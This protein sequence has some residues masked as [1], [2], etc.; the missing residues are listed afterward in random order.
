MSNP[1]YPSCWNCHYWLRFTPQGH[2]CA[3]DKKT[4]DRSCE[5]YTREPG[6]DDDWAPVE[7]VADVGGTGE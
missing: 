1:K 4:H 5:H 2:L 6:S 3:R 7:T